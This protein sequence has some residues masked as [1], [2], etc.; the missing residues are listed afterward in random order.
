MGTATGD[1][2]IQAL[3]GKSRLRHFQAGTLVTDAGLALLHEF[4]AYRNWQGGEVGQEITS[5]DAGPNSLWLNLRSPLTDRGL[6][7]LSGLEGLFALSLFGS[8]GTPSFEDERSGITA[9]GLRHLLDLPHLEW[10]GCTSRLCTDEAMEIIG[11][12]PRVRM[13]MCQDAVAGDEGFI[14]LSRSRT[15]ERIW[16]RDCENLRGRGFEALA[17]MPALRSLAVSC[18]NVDDAGLSALPRFPALTELTPIGMPDDGFRHVGGAERL[19][20]LVLMY[21]RDTTDVATEHIGR[22]PRLRKYF[23]SYTRIT[24]RSLE[25]LATMRSLE[26]IQFYGC[27]GVTD[28]GVAALA[29]APSLRELQVSGPKLTRACTAGFP[30]RIR[31]EYST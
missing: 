24:D 14:A 11:R 17:A 1:G 31:V 23:A 29:S 4:P 9:G 8:A 12:M 18:K 15:I 30:A 27:P 16:G 6:A 5:L 7:H 20:S 28:A 3:T 26:S 22:L 10:L 25:I 2:V 13:L 19:E 21:C